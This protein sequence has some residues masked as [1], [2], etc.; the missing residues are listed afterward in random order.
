MNGSLVAFQKIRV[1]DIAPVLTRSMRAAEIR[2]VRP[3]LTSSL[4]PRCLMDRR[5]IIPA[6]VNYCFTGKTLAFP[7]ALARNG[8][9]AD[10]RLSEYG[11]FLEC[12]KTVRKPEAGRDKTPRRIAMQTIRWLPVGTF[13]PPTHALG[14]RGATHRDCLSASCVLPF[15]R[16]QY[17]VC[18]RLNR[19]IKIA[20]LCIAAGID[21]KSRRSFGVCPPEAAGPMPA[22]PS[23]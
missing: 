2:A 19:Y 4:K 1:S 6:T 15:C 7:C 20:A 17:S 9:M 18:R 5:S 13:E 16:P 8:Q 22:R 23:V 21:S 11:N 14:K 3:S 12:P 10:V